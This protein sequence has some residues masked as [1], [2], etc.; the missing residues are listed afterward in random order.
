MALELTGTFDT[1]ELPRIA[2]EPVTV[3]VARRV[4][5]GF[6]AQFL[7]WADEV[8]AVMGRFHG[9]LGAG[10]FHPGPNG[11]DYQIVF[12]F[13]DGVHLREWERSPQRA[14]LMARA[15]EFVISE[16][17][18]RTV[19]V[20]RF[21]TLPANAERPRPLWKRIVIDVAWVYPVALG[22]SLLV[23]PV[24]SGLPPVAGTLVSAAIIT[25]V[26]RL[27]I[28]PLRSKLRSKRGL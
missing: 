19:G 13:V 6:E 2:D 10:V 14:A 18:Q 5:P 22:V 17:V 25:T 7:R 11:G 16:R 27:A 23:A 26:M 1:A 3:T 20:E 21:F 4:E 12:R 8:V 28:G 24:L 9:S 15:D